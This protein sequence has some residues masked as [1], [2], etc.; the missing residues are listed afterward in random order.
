MGVAVWLARLTGI[1]AGKNWRN[2]AGIVV[3]MA[4]GFI[5]VFLV[6]KVWGKV[7]EPMKA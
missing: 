5:A 4:V 7:A 6:W 3:A 2:F 1:Y